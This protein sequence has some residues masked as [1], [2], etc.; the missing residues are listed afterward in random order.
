[1]KRESIKQARLNDETKALVDGYFKLCRSSY[2][3]GVAA[4]YTYE[5]QVPKVAKAKIEGLKKYYAI[6]SEDG[7]K[8]FN[9]HIT[10]DEWHSEECAQLLEQLP[11]TDKEKAHKAAIKAAQLLWG[12]LDG[13]D[14]VSG[15]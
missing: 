4:L 3:E 15:A 6:A 1:M 2:A 14:R 12:F 10:A 13:V 11:D 8:F 9:V 5:Q 7:L